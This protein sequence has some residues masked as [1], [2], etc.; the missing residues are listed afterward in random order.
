MV[1]ENTHKAQ[2]SPLRTSTAIKSIGTTTPNSSRKRGPKLAFLRAAPSPSHAVQISG[3]FQTAACSLEALNS[4]PKLSLSKSRKARCTPFGQSNRDNVSFSLHDEF[5]INIKPHSCQ[6]ILKPST[7]PKI[8]YGPIF[9]PVLADGSPGGILNDRNEIG[10]SPFLSSNDSDCHSSHR[11]PFII[12]L[13]KAYGNNK[14]EEINTWRNAIPKS[15]TPNPQNHHQKLLSGDDTI[16]QSF[17]KTQTLT[18]PRAFQVSPRKPQKL[19]PPTSNPLRR[20]LR[21]KEN[22]NPL[23]PILPSLSLPSPSSP[24]PHVI[25]PQTPSRLPY[26]HANH[27][28]SSSPSIRYQLPSTTL[29][30]VSI[31]QPPKRKQPRDAQ[32]RPLSNSSSP[33]HT[34]AT[35]VIFRKRREPGAAGLSPYVETYRKGRRPRRER[36]ASYWDVDILGGAGKEWDGDGDDEGSAS[37]SESESEYERDDDAAFSV[38]RRHFFD[39]VARVD[40]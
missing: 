19:K 21:I 8:P 20:A 14:I 27:K 35:P 25:L 37:G 18:R 30:P 2:Q 13:A 23:Y 15:V 31:A 38:R 10:T 11:V 28:P 26:Y 34:P 36:C 33:G 9:Q 4:A 40:R 39:E 1:P 7:P 22:S 17:P 32:T 5:A 6:A 24:K 16:T 3:I 29:H 12:P